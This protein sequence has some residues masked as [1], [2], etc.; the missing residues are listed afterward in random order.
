LLL[1]LLMMLMP[2]H[3]LL[4]MLIIML[5]LLI[6]TILLLL[7]MLQ[8]AAVA[9][10]ADAAACCCCCCYACELSELVQAPSSLDEADSAAA[11]ADMHALRAPA[12]CLPREVIYGSCDY[13]AVITGMQT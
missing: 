10:A 1:L 6:M 13:D 5:L 2:M 12:P 3:M 9:A 8:L 11:L 7:Q 4:L